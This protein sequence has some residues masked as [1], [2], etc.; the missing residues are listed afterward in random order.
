LEDCGADSEERRSVVQGK[1]SE[2]SELP[3]ITEERFFPTPPSKPQPM[4][5]PYQ[6]PYVHGKSLQGRMSY[7]LLYVAVGL[8]AVLMASTLQA[9]RPGDEDTTISCRL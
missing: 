3:G 5:A 4:K 9:E 8:P 7:K 1:S 2:L 6:R